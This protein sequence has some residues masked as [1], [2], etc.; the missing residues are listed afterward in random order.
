MA[1]KIA[2]IGSNSFSG[3]HMVDFFLRNTDWEIIGISRSPEYPSLFLP[4]LYKKERSSRFRFFQL[5]INTQLS[6]IIQLLDKE[7]PEIIVNFAAQGNVQHSWTNPMHW[8]T[9]NAIG[10]PNLAFNL[11]DKDYLGRYIQIS[12]PEIYGLCRNY[13]EDSNS[14]NPSTPYAVSKMAG[15]LFLMAMFKKFGFPV[16]FIR[17]VNVYGIHQQLYRIIPRTIIFLKKGVPVPLHGG[18]RAQRSFIHISDVCHGIHRVIL[19]GKA[20]EAYH[21]S[22]GNTM[23]IRDL[24]K[25]ICKKMN[26]DF[27]MSTEITEDRA[28]QDPMID[29]D[30]SRAKEELFWQSQIELYNG[31][32]EVI[33]WINENWNE[34]LK[35]P[36]DYVHQK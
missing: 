25:L 26:R 36:L 20:G 11:K 2:I 1:K 35:Y 28:D 8:L 9:T 27:E 23:E 10:V 17:S 34:I 7:K 14:Y 16:S 18:G 31:I 32:C 13:R 33:Q 15:D 22:G 30:C 24:V 3:S 6:E 29:L 5:N 21:F 19:D 12:T 4:Y